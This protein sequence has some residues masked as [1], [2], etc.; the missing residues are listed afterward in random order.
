MRR[1][2]VRRALAG[3]LIGVGCVLPGVS[4][5]VMAVSFGLYRPMLES[6]LGFF[7]SPRKNAAFLLPLALGGGAGLLAGAY[8][9]NLAMASMEEAMLFLFTGFIVGGVPDLLREAEAGGRFRPVWL[10]SLA[11]GVALALPM[12]LISGGGP[13]R[14]ALAPPEWLLCG[15]L[16]GVGTVVPGISTS[17]VLINLGW[18][19][20]YLRALSTLAPMPLALVAAGFA[21]SALASMKAVKWLFDHVRGHAYYAVLGFL[22]VSVALVF[23][24]FASARQTLM[25]LAAMLVGAWSARRLSAL[26]S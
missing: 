24:G 3:L 2:F 7:K 5:G 26:A 22:L 9:L 20:A 13:A 16:E 25:G 8:G 10:W 14:D 19:Q 21:L 15:L 17:F 11:L 1:G 23:P 18:Y 12:A 6:L 4:G